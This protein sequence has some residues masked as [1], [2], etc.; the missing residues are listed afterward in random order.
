MAWEACFGKTA[1]TAQYPVDRKLLN[2]PSCLST[3]DDRI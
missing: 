3:E 1:V 2:S